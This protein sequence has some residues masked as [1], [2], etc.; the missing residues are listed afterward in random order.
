MAMASAATLERFLAALTPL[1]QRHAARAAYLFGSHARGNSDRHSDIDVII[2]APSQHP[3]VD[4]FKDYLPAIIAAGAGVDLFVY[5]PQE[6]EQLK[7]EERPF[8]VHA[9]EGAKLIY[10]G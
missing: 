1:L 3:A 10:E 4:R 6:F 5:T 9:L 7:R 2:V 8:L